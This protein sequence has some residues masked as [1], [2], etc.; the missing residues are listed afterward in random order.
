MPSDDGAAT[1]APPATAGWHPV[2][3]PDRDQLGPRRGLPG[4]RID[5]TAMRAWCESSCQGGWTVRQ[6]WTSGTHYL[7]EDR[8]DALAFA[9]RFFPFKCT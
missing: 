5:H 8:S 4:D 6:S 3:I 7:F 9:L 2:R 1:E